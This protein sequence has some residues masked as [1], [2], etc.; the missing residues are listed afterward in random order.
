MAETIAYD[1][2][3]YDDIFLECRDHGHAWK[4]LGKWRDHYG[5]WNRR[6]RCSTCTMGRKDRYVRGE[7]RRSYDPPDGYYLTEKIDRWSF[8]YEALDRTPT[9]SSEEELLAAKRPRRNRGKVIDIT[10]GSATRGS[11]RRT[12]RAAAAR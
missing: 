1:L 10:E 8:K 2:S 11:A 3:D 6:L 9:F 5:D 4:V 12:G 7:V